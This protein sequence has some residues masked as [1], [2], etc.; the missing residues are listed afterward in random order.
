MMQRTISALLVCLALLSACGPSGTGA[1]APTA[2]PSAS[3]APVYE[4][5]VLDQGATSPAGGS[6]RAGRA[7]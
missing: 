2:A 3:P 6:V 4:V 7:T 5:W 1:Q